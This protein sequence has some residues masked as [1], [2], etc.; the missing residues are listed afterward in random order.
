MQAW[1]WE[2]EIGYINDV[3]SNAKRAAEAFSGKSPLS[4]EALLIAGY[5]ATQY[6]VNARTRA[7]YHELTAT[8]EIGLIHDPLLHDLAS[9]LYNVPDFSVV[10]DEGSNN[11]YRK[12]VRMAIPYELHQA[13]AATCGDLDV[14]AG[15]YSIAHSLACPCA[16]GVPPHIIEA[17][18]AVLRSDPLFLQFLRLRIIDRVTH[19]ENL[20][21]FYLK[22]AT[23]CGRFRESS[24]ERVRGTQAPQRDSCRRASRQRGVGVGV[25]LRKQ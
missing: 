16:S 10:L 14:V 23:G 25:K 2:D 15:D 4:D 22:S 6:E 11:P 8:G 7:I 3:V 24:V 9:E 21:N 19:Q 13:I 1:A 18:V 12:A 20:T 5:R 17:S